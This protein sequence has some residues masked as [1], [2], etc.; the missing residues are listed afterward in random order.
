MHVRTHHSQLFRSCPKTVRVTECFAFDASDVSLFESWRL[1]SWLSSYVGA[2]FRKS[3]LDAFD[4][5]A[6]FMRRESRLENVVENN[7]FIT[8][9]F[10]LV[11]LTVVAKRKECV[12][13]KK[14]FT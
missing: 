1:S 4:A 6:V 8:G 14:I 12:G 5:L 13:R 3:H 9:S 2:K 10:L 11:N 7:A